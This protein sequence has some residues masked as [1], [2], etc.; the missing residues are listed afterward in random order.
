MDNLY[1]I[2]PLEW[3]QVLSHP[4]VTWAAGP[5][6]IE[7]NDARVFLW[8]HLTGKRTFSAT[9]QCSTLEGAKA[10][11]ESHRR[12]LLEA[13]LELVY[14]PISELPSTNATMLL[15]EGYNKMLRDHPTTEL[16]TEPG[17]Y[18]F[19]GDSRTV[20]FLENGKV[21]RGLYGTRVD[22]DKWDMKGQWVRIP[23]PEDRP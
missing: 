11:C 18:W 3:V 5:Y 1:R 10:A 8:E 6:E 7:K 23:E 20:W 21:F 12:K 17:W 16:P 19:I 14:E 13:E 9:G 15:L 22:R 4:F 2:K